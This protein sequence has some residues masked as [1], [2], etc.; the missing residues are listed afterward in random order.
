MNNLRDAL[1]DY[2]AMRRSLG[3]KLR[4]A[5]KGLLD[6][7]SF[8]EKKNASYITTSLALEWA[9]LSLSV[10]PQAWAQRLSYVR[11]F[12][13]YRSA[14]DSRTEIPFNALLP[15]RPKRARP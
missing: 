3:F 13:K 14:T 12:A 7:V 8:L 10:Q 5:G 1:R 4:D 9:Q 11:G 6:F 2:L 15:Y